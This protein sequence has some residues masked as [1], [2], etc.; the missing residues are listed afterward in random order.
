MAMR[1]K[2]IR[3]IGASTVLVFLA[4]GA[5]AQTRPAEEIPVTIDP[6]AASAEGDTVPSAAAIEP[7]FVYRLGVLAGVS[8]DNFW[9]FYGESPS[10]W[11][12]Y[13]LGPTKAA[14]FAL[15][16]STGALR[17]ELAMTEVSPRFDKD[18]WRV[19]VTLNPEMHWSDGTPITSDDFVFTFDTVRRLGL[20]GSWA[21]S[22]PEE[23]ESIHADGPHEVRIEFKTRPDLGT[24]PNAVGLAP[25]MPRHVW[26]ALTTDAESLYALS[27]TIDVAS[28]PLTI[29]SIEDDLIVATANPGFA[30]GPGP[31]RVEYHVFE[32]ETAAAG[33]LSLG[34]ID[35]IMTPDGLNPEQLAMLEGQA[36]VSVT[37]SPANGVRYLGFNLNRA[38]M[39]DQAFR[40]ALALVIDRS[41]MAS[42]SVGTVADTFVGPANG[43]WYDQESADAIAA[44]YQGDL[45]T[46]FSKAMELLR[47]AGYAWA[48]EP[49][50][51]GEGVTPGTG[52]IIRGQSPGI[53]TILTTGEA[54]DPTRPLH[55][56]EIANA[57]E[58][59][60]FEVRPV[61]TDFDT[62]VD[63]T[64]TPGEDGVMHYDMY[65]LGWT[66]GNPALPGFY[67]PLF[68]PGGVQN[69]TGY[70][71]DRFGIELARFESAYDLD[72][73]RNAL[74][75]MEAILAEDLP[76]LLL[77]T[78]S[79][80]EAFRSDRIAFEVEM[81]L[82]GIQGR[83]GGI[84][85][86]YP[87]EGSG[88]VTLAG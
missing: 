42:E 21:L 13:V 14:L 7:P 64:F 45:A 20:G 18:G 58:W 68:S 46:R 10:V 11:D 49:V 19:R 6:A 87:V 76:Y 50:V 44:K 41:A 62:V 28:G 78:T 22:Y 51:T 16:S 67:R 61:E 40:A 35:S 80:T 83:L 39:S 30:L 71:S 81:S 3:A 34:S 48:T 47:S 77:Y 79:I 4:I 75:A 55:A 31:D 85:D 5:V 15:D 2:T 27:G 74:W 88:A 84:S 1:D 56:A 29:E 38:P 59:F 72:T 12:A 33:A 8:T 36:G 9:A 53:L 24:W 57:L 32:D 66:L 25:V 23:I 17:P 52:L 69:N 65:I 26:D 54:Y 70:S 73:A 60:G 86:V 43:L 37:S 82:G 63:L